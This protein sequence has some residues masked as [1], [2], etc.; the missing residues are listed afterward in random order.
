MSIFGPK[1]RDKGPG[2]AIIHVK[3]LYN[4]VCP[5][6]MSNRVLSG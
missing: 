6:H 5:T 2:A 4:G 3:I 1:I